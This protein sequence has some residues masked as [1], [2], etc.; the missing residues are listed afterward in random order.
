MEKVTYVA[1]ALNN[2]G[3]QCNFVFVF[4][5]PSVHNAF[6]I[7]KIDDKNTELNQSYTKP[8]AKRATK[9]SKQTGK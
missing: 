9:F 6:N 5:G 8:K 3:K 2:F 4:N 7:D 1:Q